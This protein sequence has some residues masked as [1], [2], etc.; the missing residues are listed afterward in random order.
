[1]FYGLIIEL[2][3][4][5]MDWPHGFQWIPSGDATFVGVSRIPNFPFVIFYFPFLLAAIY[6]FWRAMTN[7]V[8]TAAHRLESGLVRLARRGTS[9]LPKRRVRSGHKAFL[10][11]ARRF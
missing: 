7:G 8:T 10:N 2:V 1:M 4:L 5:R 9:A 3:R 11:G 6:R